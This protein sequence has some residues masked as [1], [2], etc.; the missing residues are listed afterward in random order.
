MSTFRLGWQT[1]PPWD[2]GA[3]AFLFDVYSWFPFDSHLDVLWTRF[4]ISLF[5]VPWSLAFEARISNGMAILDV[6]LIVTS[7]HV[8]WFWPRQRRRG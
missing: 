6:A 5:Y 1:V 8:S 2:A 3:N 4:R 7:L